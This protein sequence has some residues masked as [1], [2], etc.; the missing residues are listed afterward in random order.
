MEIGGLYIR[1]QAGS[2]LPLTR[3]S[4][5]ARFSGLGQ[6]HRTSLAGQLDSLRPLPHLPC[7]VPSL[8]AGS[9][10][11]TGSQVP[12][13]DPQ[14]QED[15]AIQRSAQAE[16]QGQLQAGLAHAPGTPLGEIR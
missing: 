7:T 4:H 2:A 13:P 1:Q 8:A 14:C 15:N 16:Q 5:P 12:W 6:E 11:L 3:F 10:L 9:L